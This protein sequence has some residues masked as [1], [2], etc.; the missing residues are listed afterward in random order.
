MQYNYTDKLDTK[1]KVKRLKMWR[2]QAEERIEIWPNTCS[3][4]LSWIKE[5]FYI[6]A[7]EQ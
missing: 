2:K 6:L 7:R 5:E 3:E 4:V 1:E